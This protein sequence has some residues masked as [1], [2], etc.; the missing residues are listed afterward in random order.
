MCEECVGRL[1]TPHASR[2]AKSPLTRSSSLQLPRRSSVKGCELPLRQSFFLVPI[3]H[4]KTF[5]RPNE[6][7]I[8]SG[9]SPIVNDRTQEVGCHCRR[10]RHSYD[11]HDDVRL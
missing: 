6:T 11:S 7:P 4:V 2:F 3:G 8:Y 5:T 1:L 9:F 10:G